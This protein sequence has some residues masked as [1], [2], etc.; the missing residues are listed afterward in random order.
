LWFHE[1][2]SDEFWTGVEIWKSPFSDLNPMAGMRLSVTL[3]SSTQPA[4]RWVL[5]LPVRMSS[6]CG[7]PFAALR[8]DLL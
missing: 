2:S 3:A 7:S 6:G 4:A 8:L 1:R 5:G